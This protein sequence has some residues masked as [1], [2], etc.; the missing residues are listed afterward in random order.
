MLRVVRAQLEVSMTHAERYRGCSVHVWTV[1]KLQF[2]WC[3]TINLGEHV[4]SSDVLGKRVQTAL[5]EGVVAARMRIDLRHGPVRRADLPRPK[6][7]SKLPSMR[8]TRSGQQPAHL[9]DTALQK[10]PI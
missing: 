6:G 10:L 2:G 7:G 5:V 3:Y 8:S 4:D 1:G 9:P